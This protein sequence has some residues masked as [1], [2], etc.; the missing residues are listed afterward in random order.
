MKSIFKAIVSVMVLLPALFT[1]CNTENEFYEVGRQPVEIRYPQN[2]TIWSLDYQKPDSLYRF[3][4]NC[5]RNYIDYQ[6]IFSLDPALEEKRIEVPTGIKRDYYLTTMQMD[7]ILS[8]MNIE[9]GASTVLYWSVDVVD[10]ETA[11]CD[12]VR[13]MNI[14][15][16][17]L[18]TNV[19]LLDAPDSQN[20]IQLDKAKP[21]SEI[22]F[23]WNCQ[24]T[25]EDYKLYLS[26]NEAF[27]DPLIIECGKEKSHAF[28]HQD[29][30]AL[31]EKDKAYF[32][33]SRLVYWKVEG[34]GN[35]NNPI[36]NSAVRQTTFIRY[37][38]D[39]EA[40]TLQTPAAG[41]TL[42]LAAETA[43]DEI[44]F[45]WKC[46]TTG[47][48]YTLHLFDTE[49]EASC[50]IDCG[51]EQSYSITQSDLDLLLE[52]KFEM[53]AAQKK[54]IYW[55][56]LADD[57]LRAISSDTNRVNIR[58][59]LPVVAAAPV[60]LVNAPADNTAYTL[61]YEQASTP[62]VEITWN[63]TAK[64]VTYA[65]EYSLLPDM[66]QSKTKALDGNK[67]YSFTHA[68][69]DD[70]LSDLGAGYQTKKI[71]WR[72]TSTVSVL[73]EPSETRSLMLTGMLKPLVD[74]RDVSK[75][76]TYK[77][78]KVGNA[79]WLAENL[80]AT[81]YADGASFTTVD[82]PS[83]TYTGGAVSDPQVIGQYYTW[84]TA[85]RRLNDCNESE[86]TQVQGV[87]PAGWHVSNMKDWSNMIA[88]LS[89]DPKPAS[90]ALKAKHTQY[91]QT[92]GD[93]TN[94]S[95]LG[96]VP[97]GVFWHG[98]VG[99]PDNAGADGKSGYWT[100][101]TGSATTAYMYEVFDWDYSNMAPWHYL[102]RP[103]SEGDGTASKMVN[104]RCVRDY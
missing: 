100:T 68:L 79:V 47:V 42:L 50:D 88:A 76:E 24:T 104:V 75:P 43:A 41:S 48:N 90:P 4:W 56:V 20:E 70:L 71:Y 63:C 13:K 99:A 18:P 11:W 54:K 36:E 57:P 77:V 29:L 38:R 96:F 73:T 92:R 32:G 8:A 64:N 3:S 59:F 103:W 61:N 17:N 82:L 81:K 34:K 26:M 40:V 30:D 45:E 6:I 39:P 33:E 15:R 49:L 69:L 37:Q 89:V 84:P 44:R 12:D 91:W 102:S 14:T 97:G 23:S 25:V 51:T 62:L 9:I 78:V 10:P 72:I 60:T 1:G 94:S 16:C 22:T 66:T 65:M 52:Q 83:K 67:N 101:T 19:I 53:V 27:E 58:R 74:K 31:L 85:V 93:I 7:S 21:E 86:T 2:D 98:N 87:C 28:T 80:R 95:G 55:T 46:D 5:K 35:L